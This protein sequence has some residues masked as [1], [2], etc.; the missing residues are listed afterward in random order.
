MQHWCRILKHKNDETL[1]KL[2]LNGDLWYDMY[3]II[4][5]KFKEKY[6]FRDYFLN[7][8]ITKYINRRFLKKVLMTV[9]YNSTLFSCLKYFKGSIEEVG[10]VI[11]NNDYKD[12]VELIKDFRSF[13]NGDIFEI[14]FRMEK[15]TTLKNLNFS[16]NINNNI[17]RLHYLKTKPV[18]KVIKIDGFR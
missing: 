4:I 14:L 8:N 7:A 16:S 13:C 18:I 3:T 6:R 12:I 10:G 5:L 1:E 17:I 11:S 2:N 15:A 9:N